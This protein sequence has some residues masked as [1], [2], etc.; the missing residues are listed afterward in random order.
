V[1]GSAQSA[2]AMAIVKVLLSALLVWLC[3]RS[4]DAGEVLATLGRI[5][6]GAVFACLAFMVAHALLCAW[7]WRLVCHALGV[8]A[9]EPRQAL[10]WTALSVILSQALP[11]TVGGDAYRI[12]ALGRH[13]G[14]TAAA[15]SVI[16]DRLSGL[17]V[18][19]VLAAAGGVLALWLAGQNG[20]LVLAALIGAALVLALPA[21]PL[22]I[23]EA[24]A[25]RAL[26]R[27]A[28]LV[29]VCVAIH[30]MTLGAFA[31]L[32]AGLQ[33][34]SDLWWQAVLVAPGVLLAATVP[35]SLA[36]WGLREG[37]MVIAL[38][39]FGVPS[40]EALALSIA[41]G[42]MLIVTGALGALAWA[43]MPERKIIGVRSTLPRATRRR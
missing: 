3:F 1:W 26:L 21:I 27:D 5:H 10:R 38:A 36:G 25:F 15:R 28:R 4:A 16:H 13:Y 41:Y 17:W 14:W 37:A 32:A 31:V 30:G 18:L 39:L 43:T 8:A 24:E 2:S 42:L 7:R 20:G 22:K 29:W 11:S 6:I 40:D 19:A 34:G 9:P 12:G 23:A 35:A 33:L